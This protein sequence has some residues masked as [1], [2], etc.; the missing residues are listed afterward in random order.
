MTVGTQQNPVESAE[1]MKLARAILREDMQTPSGREGLWWWRGSFYHWYGDRWHRRDYQWI[2]DRVWQ[3]L[4]DCWYREANEDGS[5][6][7]LKRVAPTREKVGNVVRGLEALCRLPYE[8]VPTWIHG[9]GPL[10]NDG[11]LITFDDMILEPLK[12]EWTERDE[13]WFEP[14]VIPV[15]HAPELWPHAVRWLQALDEWSG[16]DP[17]WAR[18]LQQWFGYCLMSHRRY[19][20]W[21]LMYGK[22]RSGKG[23]IAHVLHR[24]LGDAM[25]IRSL[26]DLAE[27]HGLAGLEHARV[28]N[29]GEVATLEHSKGERI[30]QVLKNLLGGEPISINRKYRDVQ[31]AVV[32]AAPMVQ[33]NEVPRLP[34]RGQGLSSK[35]LMLPFEQS[36]LGREQW[37]L[38]DRLDEELPGIA[39]WAA[40]GARDLLESD[41]RWA[42]PRGAAEAMDV[43]R[44]ATGPYEAFLED[45]FLKREAGWVSYKQIWKEWESWAKANK[46]VTR[47]SKNW[48]PLK[49][50]EET[51]WVLTEYRPHGGGRGFR[52]LTMRKE[53]GDD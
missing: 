42:V 40:G 51:S 28:L 49:L 39:A 26:G 18:L 16:G 1:P 4:E 47:T 35:M 10:E 37:D 52:G 44:R 43:F 53:K 24:L 33:A 22:V 20:K 3:L 13:T 9:K 50:R 34:N 38:S 32:R 36:F 2:E 6:V 46:V 45:R 27:P 31:E 29:V 11:T 8:Q 17:E 19:A 23:T 5:I 25:L 41:G 14:I 30:T 12:C 15:Q 21:L 48:L 7:K